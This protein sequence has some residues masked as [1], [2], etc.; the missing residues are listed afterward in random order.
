VKQ[1][2]ELSIICIKV[3]IYG[4]GGDESTERPHSVYIG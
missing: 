3:A 4:K 1:E 2:E